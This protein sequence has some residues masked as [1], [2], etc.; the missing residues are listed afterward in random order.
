MS[1][2]LVSVYAVVAGVLM[3]TFQLVRPWGDVSEEPAAMAEAF[4]NPRWVVAHLAGAAAFVMLAMLAQAVVAS[5]LRE[6]SLRRRSPV[7]RIAHY[8]TALGAALILPYYGAETFALHEIGRAALA[9]SPVDVVALSGSIRMNLM[10]VILFGAGLLLVAAAMV[11]FAVV[12]ARAGARCGEPGRSGW[13]PRSHFRSS[14]CRRSDGWRTASRSWWP[15]CCSRWRGRG[16]AR[17]RRLPG[18]SSGE[19]GG[20]DAHHVAPESHQ[21]RAYGSAPERRRSRARGGFAV[22]IRS[23]LGMRTT[24][25]TIRR[26]TRAQRH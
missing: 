11:C 19:V 8:G 18:A 9:G 14:R 22:H 17:E 10:A 13:W 20:A 4:A 26:P 25:P 1:K 23:P 6:Q 5:G 24:A 16:G 2:Q 12:A 15:R 21:S 3:A 7:V